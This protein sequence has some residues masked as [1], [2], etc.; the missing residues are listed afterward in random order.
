[1]R[2]SRL[3][4]VPVLCACIAPA[5]DW[6]QWRGARRDGTTTVLRAPAVW[7]KALNKVWTVA[8][9]SGYSSPVVSATRAFVPSRQGDNEVVQAIELTNGKVAWADSYPA[10]F[11][12]SQYATQMAAGP[13]STPVLHEGRLY[14]LGV[15]AILTSYD[16]AS[17]KRL[18][19]HDYSKRVD[20]GKL[21]TGTSMSPLVEGATLVVYIGDDTKG[22][23]TALDLATGA[24]KWSWEEDGPGYASP[25]VTE[26]GGGRHLITMSDKRAIGLDPSTGRLL[27]SFPFKDQWNE[28]IVTP[29]ARG[30]RVWISGVRNGTFALDLVRQG[31]NWSARQAWQN[32]EAPM[33]MSSPV[34]DGGHLYGFSSRNK[35]HFFCQDA[36]SGKVLWTTGGRD[37]ESAAFVSLD[38]TLLALVPGGELLAFRKSPKQYEEL[39]RYKVAQTGTWSHLTPVRGGVLVKDQSTLALWTIPQ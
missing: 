28:N 18:W 4:I 19:R 8:A 6:N 10:P 33:Y 37:A 13:F 25:V 32:K 22:T 14:T 1:M 12:K 5:Q 20:T 3:L 27:W 23:L 31:A 30:N 7:P 35:G 24:E 9:G 2:L 15:T 26:V 39:A 21:F 17:G 16:A 36:A 29:V 38:D 34:L 11:K